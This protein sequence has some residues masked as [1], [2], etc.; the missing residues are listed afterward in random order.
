MEISGHR[1]RSVFDRYDIVS[2]ADFYRKDHRLIF[3]AIALLSED[4]NPCDVVTVSEFLDNRDTPAR[5]AMR[6][7]LAAS[8]PA[9][10]NSSSAAS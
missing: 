7:M 6:A 4:G 2:E 8:K 9:R 3:K 1:T 5:T 10:P